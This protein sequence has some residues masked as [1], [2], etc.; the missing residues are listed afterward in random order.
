MG[1]GEREGRGKPF[2]RW[3]LGFSTIENDGLTTVTPTILFD[4]LCARRG[5]F[6][7]CL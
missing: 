2:W 6:S 4:Y 1:G 5:E 3:D 7:G